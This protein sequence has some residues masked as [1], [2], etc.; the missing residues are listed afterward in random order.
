MRDVAPSGINFDGDERQP[1]RSI[2][3]LEFR[4]DVEGYGRSDGRARGDVWDI[5]IRTANGSF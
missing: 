2:R 5:Q 4:D 1:R 3:I